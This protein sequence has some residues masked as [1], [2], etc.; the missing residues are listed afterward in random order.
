MLFLLKFKLENIIKILNQ[1][2]F[3]DDESIFRHTKI[4]NKS[5]ISRTNLY[6]LYKF[7]FFK[8]LSYILRETDNNEYNK[9]IIRFLRI[10]LEDIDVINDKLYISKNDITND[11]NKR[12]DLELQAHL[13]RQRSMTDDQRKI[14]R[15]FKKYGIGDFYSKNGK[16]DWERGLAVKLKD[17]EYNSIMQDKMDNF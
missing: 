8:I 14:D 6:I 13:K 1:I 10:N 5:Y 7:I 9:F 4:N 17:T 15:E 3:Y 16:Q 11:I 2:S 12:K